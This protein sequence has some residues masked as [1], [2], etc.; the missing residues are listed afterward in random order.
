MLV[1][2]LSKTMNKD[3]FLLLISHHHVFVLRPITS[4]N[5]YFLFVSWPFDAEKKKLDGGT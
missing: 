4:E 5:S 3:F 2:V 1:L